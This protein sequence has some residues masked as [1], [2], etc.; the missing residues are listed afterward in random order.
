VILGPKNSAPFAGDTAP[1]PQ[2]VRSMLRQN[3]HKSLMDRVFPRAGRIGFAAKA[4][5][6]YS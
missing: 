1:I 5:D 4:R 2:K 3:T 6:A